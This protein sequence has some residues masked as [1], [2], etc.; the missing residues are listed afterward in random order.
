MDL[1]LATTF[2]RVVDTGSFAAAAQRLHVT[3]GAVSRRIQALEAALGCQLFVRNRAGAVLTQAGHQFQRH[4]ASLVR[5]LEQA[6]QDVGVP[7]GYR[8]ALAIGGR[9]A[10]WEDLLTDWLRALRCRFPDVALRGEMRFDLGLMDDLVSGRLDIGVMYTPQSRPGLTVEHLLDEEL[11]MV[12][13][14]DQRNDASDGEDPADDY[15]YVKWGPEFYDRYSMQ[16]PDLLPPPI[17]TGISWIGLRYIVKYGGTSYFPRRFVSDLL[18]DGTLS[19]VP[20]AP[21]FTMPAYVV[22]PEKPSELVAQAVQVLREL[23][24]EI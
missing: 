14:P 11:V 3:Q 16:F 2:L 21:E 18:N 4:A 7:R 1:D 24:V 19:Q 20:N 10:L 22:Y 15:I 6:R 5:T 13:R 23:S 8:A 9:F 12:R 17:T